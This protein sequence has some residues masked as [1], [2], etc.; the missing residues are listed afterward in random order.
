MISVLVFWLVV[1]LR[2]R[3]VLPASVLVTPGVSLLGGLPA[4]LVLSGLPVC[5][6]RG[7]FSFLRVLGLACES[8]RW[9]IG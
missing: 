9:G 4:L 3:G 1:S 5:F 8:A 2:V 6:R 7:C